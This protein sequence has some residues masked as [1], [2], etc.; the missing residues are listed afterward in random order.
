MEQPPFRPAAWSPSAQTWQ[1]AA[2]L[3]DAHPERMRLGEMDPHLHCSVIG[4][5]LSAPELRKLMA[6]FIGVAGTSDLDVHHEAVRLASQ[7][8]EVART[9][10]RALDRRHEGTVQRF[11]RARDD[12]ALAALWADSLKSGE[13]P[14][15]YWAVLTHRRASVELRQQAFGEVHMLSHLMGA[16]NRADIRRLVAIEKDNAEWRERSERQQQRLAEI[17]GERDT[18]QQACDELRLRVQELERLLAARE[19]PQPESGSESSADALARAVALHTRRREAAEAR[20]L[21][22]AGETTLLREEKDHARAHG[23]ELARELAAAEAELRRVAEDAPAPPA[24]ALAGR[25]LL[26]V[27]GRP[28][29]SAAIRGF[30]ARLGAE[31]RHHD[32]GLE[33]RKGL[34]ASALGWAEVVAFP[35][36]CIDHDSA[37]AL[38]KAC[39][40]R[41]KRFLPLRTASVAS[42]AAAVTTLA[43][44]VN[45]AQTCA[46]PCRRHG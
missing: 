16:A 46:G 35:V 44:P 19:A 2:P 11:T 12:S 4:T 21:A 6:K 14:G 23:E 5:C 39:L 29:S 43:A 24:G 28:S 30:A 40:Q 42:L 20:A 18:A 10:H 31:F 34:L 9:L 25:R 3:Q 26:Y 7:D 36:D 22:L 38:K 27:G 8:S 1:G 45:A 41:G 37:L 17:A 32:G 33:D 13:V 15:A